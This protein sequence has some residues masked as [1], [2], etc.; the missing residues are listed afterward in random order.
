VGQLLTSEIGVYSV[1]AG[2]AFLL[3]CALLALPQIQRWTGRAD[4]LAPRAYVEVASIAFAT[5]LLCN[6]AMELFF[7]LSSASYEWFDYARYTLAIMAAYNYT[8]GSPWELSRT[9]SLVLLCVY[10]YVIVAWFAH[11][12]RAPRELLHLFTG[13]SFAALISVKSTI[14]RSEAG[15]M[16]LA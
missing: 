15:H 16:M 11:F 10:V 9:T 14:M 6:L 2:F 7:R 13:L 5:F 8:M 1:A 3:L 12:K 4:L